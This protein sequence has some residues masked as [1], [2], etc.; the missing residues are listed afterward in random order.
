MVMSPALLAAVGMYS[1]RKPLLFYDKNLVEAVRY[2]WRGFYLNDWAHGDA[3]W[4]C[5]LSVWLPAVE[6]LSV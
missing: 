5:S 4:A 1:S 6:N 2:Q 3:V